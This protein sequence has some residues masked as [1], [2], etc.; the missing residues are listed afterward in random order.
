MTCPRCHAENREGRRFCAEC[1]AS[2]A[3]ACP[4]CGF[5]NEPGEK[6]CGG[7]GAPLRYSPTVAQPKFGAPESYTPKH[8]AEKILTSKARAKPRPHVVSGRRICGQAPEWRQA[9]HPPGRATDE[10]RIGEVIE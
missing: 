4:A 5:S 3:F 6:F 10:V 2:L 9:G 7:C 8:L 1:G